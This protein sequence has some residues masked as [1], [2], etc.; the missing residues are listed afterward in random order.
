[1]NGQIVPIYRRIG[2]R[3][4]ITSQNQIEINVHAVDNTIQ[5]IRQHFFDHPVASHFHTHPHITSELLD[6][7]GVRKAY[8]PGT[9][10]E[11]T[12]EEVA[13]VHNIATPV[14][15]DGD[16]LDFSFRNRFYRSYMLG[17]TDGYTLI[18]NPTMSIPFIDKE[19]DAGEKYA[20]EL[21]SLAAQTEDRYIE[22][23]KT[24]GDFTPV[25][26]DFHR[27]AD[28]LLRDY[29]DRRKLLLFRN[30]DYKSPVLH[31]M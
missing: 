5:S 13:K 14:F 6:M 21:R 26:E 29:C 1:M 10:I 31:K 8:V 20:R 15:S 25:K 12:L 16:I 30:N 3:P 17:T 18:V 27:Q 11:T 2:E 9:D 24:E 28:R 22:M 4:K 19:V 23:K 7:L